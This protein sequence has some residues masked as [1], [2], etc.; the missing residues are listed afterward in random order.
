VLGTLPKGTTP[1]FVRVARHPAGMDRR[2]ASLS[3]L[4]YSGGDILLPQKDWFTS[5]VSE[6]LNAW[7]YLFA[8]WSVYD[9]A[10]RGFS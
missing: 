9:A 5:R 2:R 4:D 6:F 3:S 1:R 8:H 10:L 7:N